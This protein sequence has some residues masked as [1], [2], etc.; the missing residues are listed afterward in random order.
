VGCGH[1]Q[2]G[3]AGCVADGNELVERKADGQLS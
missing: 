2:N 3:C 1:V